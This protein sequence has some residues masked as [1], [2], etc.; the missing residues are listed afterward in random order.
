MSALRSNG[1]RFWTEE[2]LRNA[3]TDQ[4]TAHQ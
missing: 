2:K 4:F 1:F 3:D